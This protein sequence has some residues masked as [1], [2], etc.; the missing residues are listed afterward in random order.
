MAST[1]SPR[2]SVGGRSDRGISCPFHYALSQCTDAR[3]ISGV[4]QIV[5]EG[6]IREKVRK[7]KERM[8]I[9][10]AANEILE[11]GTA[12]A[13]DLTCEELRVLN[14]YKKR[15]G[16]SPLKN[17][18]DDLVAPWERRRNRKGSYLEEE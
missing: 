10:H 4:N 13:S 14:R 7:R 3:G 6:N 8:R 9:V 11:K 2:N 17:K 1:N 15:P 12:S 16:D 5:L 18:K